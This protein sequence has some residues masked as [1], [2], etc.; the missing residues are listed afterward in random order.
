MT[1][2][3]VGLT[4]RDI[5]AF[6][7]LIVTDDYDDDNDDDDDYYDVDYDDYNENDDDDDDDV[8]D[9]L[10]QLDCIHGL[11]E[12]LYKF[13]VNFGVNQKSIRCDASLTSISP[14]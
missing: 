10:T 4:H 5:G 3:Q 12:S 9:W 11:I 6:L 1:G 7:I 2:S 14:L 13:V 8:D